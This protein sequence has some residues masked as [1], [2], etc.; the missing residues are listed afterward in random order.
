MDLK[1]VI[2]TFWDRVGAWI[3]IGAGALLLLLGWLGVSG[4]PYVEEQVPY[5]ISAGFTGLALIGIG[6]TLWLS[7][8][9]RDEWHRLR[10]LEEAITSL[11]DREAA[12]DATSKRDAAGRSNGGVS[13]P[14]Q[15][16]GT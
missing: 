2:R 13:S 14:R 12:T 9:L 7:S 3:L 4:T 11:L 1:T 6:A 15:S 16:V 10:A 8:D 5:V